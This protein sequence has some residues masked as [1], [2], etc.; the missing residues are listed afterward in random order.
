MT[1]KKEILK[2]GVKLV[3]GSCLIYYVFFHTKMVDFAGLKTELVKPGNLILCLAFL[4]FSSVMCATRWLLLVRAQGLNLS[5]KE[6]FEL[7][8]IG[9]FFNTFMPGA[10]GGDLI[11]AW[12]V[13]GQE[14]KRKTKAVFTVLLDRLVGLSVIVLYAAV[15]L[16]FFLHWL[17]KH[18]QL[19]ALALSLWAFTG[20]TVLFSIVFFTPFLWRSK[21]VHNFLE[22]LHRWRR[23]AT[24]V[25]AT[26]LYQ[27]RRKSVAL[28]ILLS[29]LSILATSV[30]YSLQGKALGIPMP[31]SQYFFIVPVGLTVSAI[32]LLPG[33][34]GVGQVAFYTLFEWTGVSNPQLGAQLCTLLQA[35][36]IL[37]NC[38]GAFFYIKFKKKPHTHNVEITAVAANS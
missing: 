10:V 6:L 12:Y 11:K 1:R 19:K 4:S 31:L 24:I 14:P 29:M 3:V 36:T 20:A 33:G 2:F 16:F 30:L 15:T 5:F 37:F 34:I 35:Y 18:V 25:E 9:N 23:L 13:A 28:A 26:L 17:D 32:P 7:T 27:N 22:Y 8:M 21:V 38:I